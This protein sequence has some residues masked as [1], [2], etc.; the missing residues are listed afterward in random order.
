M[1]LFAERGLYVTRVEDITER[2][3]VAK[4]AFYSHFETKD[5]LIAVLVRQGVE[6][7]DSEYLARVPDAANATRRVTE[8]VKRH[9]AFFEDHPGHALLFHQARGLLLLKGEDMDPL[10]GVFADYLARL[11]RHLSGS[12]RERDLG[13]LA[14]VV[15][16]AIV[17][18]RSLRQ[19]AGR[20][21]QPTVLARCLTEGVPKQLE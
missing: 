17:G 20:G 10:R 2:A 8:I 7:L 9:H 16:G 1:G 19:A 15:G 21:L 11:A 6:V 5:A 12:G 14:A 3:D 18:Y 13:E 4:G